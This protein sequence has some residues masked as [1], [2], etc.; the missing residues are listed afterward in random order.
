MQNSQPN[1]PILRYIDQQV[2]KQGYLKVIFAPVITLGA[3]GTV[4]A[5]LGSNWLL[6]GTVVGVGTCALA[7]LLLTIEHMRASTLQEEV[8]NQG[9]Q[10]KRVTA[11]L[12]EQAQQNAAAAEKF[13]T[14]IKEVRDLIGS[15]RWL[16]ERLA[17]CCTTAI[18][19]NGTQRVQQ[20][21]L[22]VCAEDVCRVNEFKDLQKAV[23][24]FA[25]QVL[26]HSKRRLAVYYGDEK[27][28][29]P[30]DSTGWP[31]ST[32]P[33][34]LV[35]GQPA[36]PLEVNAMSLIEALKNEPAVYVEDLTNPADDKRKFVDIVPDR[37]DF[38]TLACFRLASLPSVWSK[39][40]ERATL[41]G[42]LMV[43]D[44]RA[45]AL[46]NTSEREFFTVLANALATGFLSV[47]LNLIRTRGN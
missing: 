2:R 33:R 29:E 12:E 25:V 46:S 5:V 32:N 28:L 15:V 21:E 47:R 22:I 18:P 40:T 11:D 16:T 36:A 39:N 44:A 20:G 45:D 10:I 31:P 14:E 37:Q 23:L 19:S 6:F 27:R 7:L 35:A 26:G 43:Q 4:L 1:Q 9:K 42:V 3:L 34:I 8:S 41:L 13:S 24:Y 30:M 17:V 38:R